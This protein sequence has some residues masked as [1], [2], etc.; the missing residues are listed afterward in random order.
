VQQAMSLKRARILLVVETV[1]VCFVSIFLSYITIADYILYGPVNLLIAALMIVGHP[2]RKQKM[3][4]NAEYQTVR[5]TTHFNSS[6]RS[7]MMVNLCYVPLVYIFSLS[8][9]QLK[10]CVNSHIGVRQLEVLYLASYF[11]SRKSGAN[12]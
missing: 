7:P 12:G 9:K 5:M 2:S 1:S 8:V 4:H 11:A 10:D 3:I 6:Y